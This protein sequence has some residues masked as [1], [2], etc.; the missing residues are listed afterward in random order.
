MICIWKRF[1]MCMVLIIVFILFVFLI[2]FYGFDFF[3][4]EELSIYGYCCS[5]LEL[6]NKME[7]FVFGGVFFFI[8]LMNIIFLVCLYFKIGFIICK[9]FKYIKIIVYFRMVKSFEGGVFNSFMG[10]NIFFNDIENKIGDIGLII[11][12]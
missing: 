8:F 11:V 3:L 1:V 7:L 5:R 4:N 9:Y 10:C 6:V 12:F 2:N